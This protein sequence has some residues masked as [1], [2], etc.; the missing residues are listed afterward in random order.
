[1]KQK[2]IE[3]S[4]AISSLVKDGNS[5]QLG[6]GLETAI[7]F[8]ATFELIRQGRKNLHMI[9]PISDA[10]TDMLIGG[11]CVTEVSA[12]WIGNV[13]GG[14]GHNYRRAVEK[15][16]PHPIKINDY[17]NLSLAMAL[18][19]GAYGL[20]YAPV[21]SILGSDI[22]KSNPALKVASNPFSEQEEPV[23]LIPALRPDISILAVQ[24]AD[25]FGNCHYWGSSG[26]AKE[27]GLAAKK[28]ILVAHEIVEPEVISSDPSRVLIPGFRVD[29]V[30][31]VPDGTHPSPLTGY[32]KRDSDFFN[33]YH[34]GSRDPEHFAEWAKEWITDTKDPAGYRAKLGARLDDLHI[35]GED[36]AAP[37]NYAF[38]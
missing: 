9:S 1:M 15:G 24:R 18:F 10:S 36:F 11:G 4:E 35:N 21:K 32:L 14:L 16:L 30:C 33:E 27:A 26:V 17:S 5:V 20:P 28:V 23:V 3:L 19:A 38:E 2:L 8:A 6:A 25:A 7:P 29:A 22:L 34:K 13:S 37:A 31:H 12:S